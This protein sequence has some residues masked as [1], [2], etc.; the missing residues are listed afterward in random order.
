MSNPTPAPRFR[1]AERY[2]DG[3]CHGVSLSHIVAVMAKTQRKIY[4][5]EF[6]TLGALSDLEDWL[7]AHCQGEYSLGLESMDEKREKKTVKILFSEE[8]DKLRFVAKFGKRK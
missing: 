3:Y 1:H 2:H 7:E 5:V 6:A 8:A 4:G